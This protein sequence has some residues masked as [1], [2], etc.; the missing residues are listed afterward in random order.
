MGILEQ[1]LEA[2]NR[3][4]RL[5]VLEDFIGPSLFIAVMYMVAKA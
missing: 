4:K 1:G 2:D 3:S 5:D